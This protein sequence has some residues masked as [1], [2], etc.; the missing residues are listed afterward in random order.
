MVAV[1]LFLFVQRFLDARDP[2]LRAR[3]AIHGRRPRGIPGRGTTVTTQPIERAR[4]APN[5]PRSASGWA[6]CSSCASRWPSIVIAWAALRPEAV[7]IEF[8]ALLAGDRRLPRALDGRRGPPPADRSLRSRAADR[9]APGRRPVSRLRDVRHRRDAEPDPLPGL[10]R[11]GGRVAA[12]VVS[13]RAQ[14]RAV[15]LAA[16]VRGALRPG[17]AISSRRSRSSPGAAIEFDRMPVLN[18]TSFWL[19]AIA[20]SAFSALNERELRQRRA[21]LQS[22]VEVGGRLDDASDPARAGA[23]RAGRPGRALRLQARHRP[24]R[25]RRPDDRARDARAPRTSRPRRP[26]RT[27]IVARAWERRDVLPVK[28]LDAGVDPFLAAAMPDARNL[29]VAPMIAD[30]RPVGA[31]VVEAAEA[32]P[33]AGRRAAG[34][35]DGRQLRVDGG[36]QPAQRRAPPPRPGP[37]RAR[38]AD[39]RGQP[40]DVPAEPRA[41][42]RGAR[43][44]SAI[45]DRITAVLFIDLDDFK[46]VND[47]LGHAAGDALLV[48]VT[49]RISGLVRDATSSPASAATSSP[50]LTEDEP[51]LARSRAMAERLV[52]RAAGAVRDRRSARR[53]HREHRHR[54]RPRRRSTAR[55]TSSATPTSRCTW[56]RPTARPA[57]PS[58]TRACTPRIRER[59]ELERE[60]QRAVELDQLRLVYQPIVDLADRA[61]RRGRGAGPLAASRRAA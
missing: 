42:A 29:L 49:E 47:T 34:R 13:D 24:R 36:A 16:A 31:I 18:V 11:P 35:L 57:S 56:P 53:R 6:T 55:P 2:K 50:I 52:A 51:D 20:T 22:M 23:D 37:G 14:D 5:T 43:R 59:H 39:R 7:G 26:S 3:P 15:G 58:S 45:D 32:P 8:A 33:P 21:D 48:A 60:L 19:F 28:R 27:A 4:P 9:P 38:L 44:R 61:D 25:L 40:A 54:Q 30:G 46:V 10:P 12:G 17:R 1:L 41:D